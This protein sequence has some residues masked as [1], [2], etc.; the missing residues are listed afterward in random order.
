MDYDFR[1]RSGASYD[2]QVPMYRTASSS[3]PSPHPMYGPSLYPRVGQPQPGHTV[4]PSAANRP[5]SYHH[6]TTTTSSSSSS[7]GLGIRVMI[8]PQYRITPPPQLSPQVGDIP[9]SNF[10]FDFDFE[11]KV[12]A[13]AEKES[14][15]WSRLGMENL[16]PRT[17]ESTSSTGSIADPV[18]SKYISMGLSRDAVSLAV[19]NYGDDPTKVRDFVNGYTLL[20]EMGFSSSNVAEALVVYENDTDKALAHFLNSSS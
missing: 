13:E 5:S 3:A 4:V 20:R 11:R 15:N 7:S 1:T 12:L 16:P 19:A 6:H 17:T 9:R 14:Q 18:V 8:K 2:P 10:Q